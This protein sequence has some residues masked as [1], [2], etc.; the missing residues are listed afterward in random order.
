[1]LGAKWVGEVKGR[2][3][4]NLQSSKDQQQITKLKLKQHS[5]SHGSTLKAAVKGE[6]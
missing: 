6:V 1:V 3:K 2:K 4:K 5:Q